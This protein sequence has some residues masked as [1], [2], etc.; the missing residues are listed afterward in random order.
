MPKRV[1]LKGQTRE[2]VVRLQEY[3]EKESSHG[4]PLIPVTKVRDRVAAALGIGTSTVTKICKVAYDD[5]EIVQKKLSTPMKKR[6]RPCRVTAI[7]D[8]NADGIRCHVY[9]YYLRK[10]VPTLRKMLVSLRTNGFILWSKDFLS[11]STKANWI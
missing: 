11:D 9:D 6:R 10:E 4:R 5:N 2:F 1:V 3:F 7:D 8:F